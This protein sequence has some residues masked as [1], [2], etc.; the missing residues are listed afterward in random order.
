MRRIHP[1]AVVLSFFLV[2]VPAHAYADPTGGTLFQIIMPTLAALWA[3]WLIF[4]NR[5]RT[6]VST[7]YRRLRGIEANETNEVTET[8]ENS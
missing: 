2:G 5:V 1:I 3:M 8:A 4:A 7:L 6:K